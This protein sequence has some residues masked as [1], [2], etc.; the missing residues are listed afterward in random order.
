MLIQYLNWNSTKPNISCALQHF[1]VLWSFF[2]GRWSVFWSDGILVPRSFCELVFWSIVLSVC[3]YI[4]LSIW[5]FIGQFVCRCVRL[6]ECR[7]KHFLHEFYHWRSDCA[8]QNTH[9]INQHLMVLL[10]IFT[11]G[12]L[13]TCQMIAL[14]KRVAGLIWIYLD[15]SEA[16]KS[17]MQ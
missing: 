5:Q 13:S 17:L 3:K 16:A 7:S 14:N 12:I 8:E 4:A 9:D 10:T 11:N 6:R 2:S 1:S 15:I